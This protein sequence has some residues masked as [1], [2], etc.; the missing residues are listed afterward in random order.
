LFS[1]WLLVLGSY[2]AMLDPEISARI[3]FHF[4]SVVLFVLGCMVGSFLNVCIYRMP[5]GKS[6]I[7]PASHCPHC[8]YS[9]PF[10]LNVPLLTWLMLGG[11]CANCRQPISIRYFMVE[12]LT[13]L[14]FVGCW[15]GYGRETPAVALTYCSGPD[16]GD[17]YRHRSFHHSG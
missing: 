12:L 11:R 7:S 5:L 2:L 9:I 8:Q 15:V 10:Y 13:G 4:W 16:G 6:I 1:V 3:P 17:F 14:M